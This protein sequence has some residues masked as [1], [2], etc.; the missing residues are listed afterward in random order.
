MTAS[1][2]E[3]PIRLGDPSIDPAALTTRLRQRAVDRRVAGAYDDALL[4]RLAEPLL[5]DLVP[6][7]PVGAAW[8]AAAA[9]TEV[10][11]A[12]PLGP[13]SG[14]AGRA[15]RSGQR[16]VRRGLRW[17]TEELTRQLSEHHRAVMAIL[18]QIEERVTALERRVEGATRGSSTGEADDGSG[19]EPR[20]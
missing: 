3:S 13:A 17:H 20:A 5:I 19:D 7:L 4:D 15:V 11:V 18:L 10:D 1:P 12:A 14:R 2:D 16:L 8:H 9:T 6:D